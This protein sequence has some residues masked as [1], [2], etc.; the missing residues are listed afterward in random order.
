[1]KKQSLIRQDQH[2]WKVHLQRQQEPSADQ[3]VS[4]APLPSRETP[5]V[6]G[7][8]DAARSRSRHQ[9]VQGVNDRTEGLSMTTKRNRNGIVAT[10][11]LLTLSL[12]APVWGG[13]FS[14]GIN[15]ALGP[16]YNPGSHQQPRREH[17]GLDAVRRWNA[18]A[19][20]ASGLDHTPVASGE[21]RI[22]GE[23]LGPARSSR[24]MA[25]VH[26]AIFDAV[27]AITG[28]YRSYTG[29]APA[30]KDTSMSAAIAQA[31]HDT[32]AEL[33]P[34]QAPDLSAAL[35]EDLK[36]IR[37]ERAKNNGIDVGRRA[38]AAIL[39]LRQNDGSEH[40]EP[41]VGVDYITSDE[42]GKWR[43]DPISQIP[44]ALGARWAEVKPFVMKS[45]SQF[46]VPPPPA[47][48]SRKYAAA[49]DE[50]KELGGDGIVTPTVRTD[51]QTGIGIFWAYDGTPSLCAP[52]RLY[53]QVTTQIAEQMA[54]NT[55]ELA[56]L[57]ALV[58]TAMAD[59]AIAIWESKYYYDYWRPVTGIREADEGTGPTGK[60]DGNPATVGDPAYSPL[61]APASNL[62]GPNFTPPFPAYP[63]G[64][65]GFGGALFQI[66]RKFYGRD[67]V[68]FTFVSDEYNGI[69]QD[70]NGVVRPLK[71]RSFSSLSE[72]EEE[73][74]Q[75]RIYLGIHWAFDKT[76]GIAQ[77]QR[78]GNYV[79]DH[80][81]VPQ[82]RKMKKH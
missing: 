77:G 33:F 13:E 50:V 61:G 5:T 19:I 26:I 24:A 82:H 7:S 1:M 22:F 39:A 48:N 52:P 81:F 75:S 37:D 45:A 8:I 71:P 62:N 53:N 9:S 28:G 32:L 38:A 76:E 6:L 59:A 47:L 23:Q 67:R 41:R 18:I 60:G 72:A 31:A 2:K 29:I 27:I 40:P 30:A 68:P 42:P 56:R 21:T 10:V 63:S 80:A 3:P 14:R 54:L 74:G 12:A 17:R 49:F 43:Q 57:L 4:F 44:L 16:R 25:M 51:E 65:A 69:T 79:F 70:N 58:N 20:D 36:S 15:D 78:V 46:R 35:K 55:V 73:N 66:L 64:H 34:S 11:W